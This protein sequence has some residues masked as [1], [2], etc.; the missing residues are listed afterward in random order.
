MRRRP[1]DL[2][3]AAIIGI[4][5][6]VVLSS[7]AALFSAWH[8][9]GLFRSAVNENF[10]ALLAAEELEIALLEQR[11]LVSSYMIEGGNREWLEELQRRNDAFRN[12]LAEARNM[13]RTS[14]QMETLNQLERV[15]R[16][17]D[18]TRDEVVALYDR[19][20][21]D[22]A[23]VMFLYELNTIYREAYLLCED[24]VAANQRYVDSATAHA[25]G[26]IR[27][28]TLMVLV[29]VGLTMG[30]GG[31]SLWILAR[32]LRAEQARRGHEAHLLAARRIQERLLPDTVPELPGLDIHSVWYP[33]EF[34]AGDYY[35]YLRFSDGSLGVVVGDV[36]GHGIGPALLMASARAYL[37]SLVQTRMDLGDILSLA[38][39]ILVGDIEEGRF[40]TLVLVRLDLRSKSLTYVNAGHPSG[41]VL[42]VSGNVKARLKST[43]LPLGIS[44]DACFATSDPIPLTPG[45][46][47]VLF[48]DGIPEAMCPDGGFFG[49]ERT[50]EFF[51]ANRT[52]PA[53]EIVEGLYQAVCQHAG[54]GELT[55]DVT[56]TV[57]KVEGGQDDSQGIGT[58]SK[59]QRS[60]TWCAGTRLT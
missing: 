7:L 54:P 36:S 57:I 51:R 3:F 49:T 37:R 43:T 13:V 33:A 32:G 44:T 58:A 14:E 53:R 25:S 42:D 12:W 60:S 1:T 11:G 26:R 48:S 6:L 2:L 50:L 8:I 40:I 15:Y 27:W 17:Y 20:N 23:Y 52:R 16:T 4:T 47:I 39:S 5:A 10:P 21:I 56:A 31:V 34:A 46:V 45:D 9:A 29:C 38:N 30:L 19:G 18:G 28:V 35:D 24:F 59:D 22:Q 41:Y 55:D